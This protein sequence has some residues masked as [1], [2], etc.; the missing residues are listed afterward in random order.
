MQFSKNKEKTIK[1]KLLSYNQNERVY[2]EI[3]I[4]ILTLKTKLHQIG[5]FELHFRKIV[6]C[7]MPLQNLSLIIAFQVLQ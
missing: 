5:K 1:K 7:C 3:T 6:L 2:D 4:V